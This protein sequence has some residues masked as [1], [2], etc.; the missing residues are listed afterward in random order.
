ME[1]IKVKIIR[2]QFKFFEQQLEEYLN[3]GYELH[4]NIFID[5]VTNLYAVLIRK[6]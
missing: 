4:S 3:D 1:K 6:N 2:E 5:D